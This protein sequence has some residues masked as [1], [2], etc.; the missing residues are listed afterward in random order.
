MM[1]K[2]LQGATA[3]FWFVFV[4]AAAHVC[5]LV[6]HLGS[7]MYMVSKFSPRFPLLGTLSRKFALK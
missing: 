6:R 4:V 1:R 2:L 3:C 5:D 7:E